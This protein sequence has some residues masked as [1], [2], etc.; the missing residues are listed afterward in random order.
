MSDAAATL[1]PEEKNRI[2]GGEACMW[3][4]WIT[5]E[6]VDSHIW[7]RSAAIAE[8]LWSPQSVTDVASM[9]T[10]LDAIS[11]NLE[12]LGLTHRSARTHMLQRMAGSEDISALRVLADVVEPVKDYE[13][14][15]F[16]H[17]PVDVRA[18]LTR[19]IDAVYPESDIAREFSSLVQQFVQSGYKDQATKAQMR[20]W[21]TLWRDN[22]AKLHPLLQQ[23]ALL[24][25]D[26]PLSQNLAMVAAAGLQAL[27]YLDKGLPEPDLWKAQ[28]AA[29]IDQAKKPAA[30]LLLMV[31]G[32]VE[33]LVQA[34]G[35]AGHN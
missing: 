28:Q 6:N 22:D 26:V 24:Q 33:Q 8:R 13:R 29:V 30:G 4:E 3:A 12:W 32:P 25:E 20:N 21:L 17:Q 7:P 19:L 35:Q 9:Y 23:S 34:A 11:L 18:P 5:P 16:E 27:D 2:L 15:K 1:T 14:E 10:R 31:V